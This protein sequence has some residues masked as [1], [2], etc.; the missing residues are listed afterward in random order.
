MKWKFALIGLVLMVSLVL[1][2]TPG[3]SSQEKDYWDTTSAPTNV[4]VPIQDQGIPFNITITSWDTSSLKGKANIS[5]PVYAPAGLSSCLI[6]S[7]TIHLS[8]FD[9]PKIWAS[10]RG[11]CKPTGQEEDIPGV[12]QA[13]MV[14]C[15]NVQVGEGVTYFNVT[16]TDNAGQ[17]STASSKFIID[18]MRPYVDLNSIQ[19]EHVV[20]TNLENQNFDPKITFQVKDLT[21]VACSIKFKTF[22]DTDYSYTC[23]PSSTSGEFG[24]V[25]TLQMVCYPETLSIPLGMIDITKGSTLTC[26][27][28]VGNEITLTTEETNINFGVLGITSKDAKDLIFKMCRYA[29]QNTPKEILNMYGIQSATGEGSPEKDPEGLYALVTLKSDTG[30]VTLGD[31]H[32]I[33]DNLRTYSEPRDCAGG[34]VACTGLCALDIFTLATAKQAAKT[35]VEETA[36]ETSDEIVELSTK[37]I[38]EAINKL[39]DSAK[40]NLGDITK[41]L[42]TVDDLIKKG[43]Y[44]SAIGKLDNID[45]RL[46]ELELKWGELDTSKK[47]VDIRNSINELEDAL[48]STKSSSFLARLSQKTSTSLWGVLASPW[49]LVGMPTSKLALGRA[50]V[51]F[52]RRYYG[53]LLHPLFRTTPFVDKYEEELNTALSSYYIKNPAIDNSYNPL[54]DVTINTLEAIMGGL[55]CGDLVVTAEQTWANPDYPDII[56]IFD[57]D[58]AEYS[59]EGWGPWAKAS[60]N[61]KVMLPGHSYLINARIERLDM[62]KGW[63]PIAEQLGQCM[64]GC[65]DYACVVTIVPNQ[66]EYNK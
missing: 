42:D 53:R 39:P 2:F 26:A 57:K 22:K 51:G 33:S 61:T 10:F 19:F 5:F 27:D 20:L 46:G 56:T 40:E 48:K 32:R 65:P 55:P 45:V 28:S 31:I 60:E 6:Q 1:A 29:W 18:K 64:F 41:Q 54:F 7:K 59:E 11:T 12:G 47:I 13:V 15:S 34:L 49:S 16:C 37:E 50:F 43:D 62:S 8:Y 38:K 63:P 52:A 24:E 58:A 9:E 25:K 35:T 17:T 4:V 36:K 30:S 23:L 3:P 66:E 14:E 44:D 21:D